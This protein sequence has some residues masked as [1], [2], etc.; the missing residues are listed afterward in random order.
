MIPPRRV[1]VTGASGFIGRHVVPQLVERGWDVHAVVYPAGRVP[2][3]ATATEHEVN[4]LAP[5]APAALV[6]RVRPAYLM[7]LAW[8][9]VPGRF[10]SD[11]D[12]LDW[13]AASLALHR[14]FA[15]AGGTR[16]VYAGT[17]AE[18]DWSHSHLDET[19][20]PLRPATLYGTAKHALRQLLEAV[21]PTLG[22]AVAWGRVFFLYGPYEH[23]AR[24]VPDVM[25]ALL[26]GREAHCTEGTQRRDLMH[27][28]D[29]AGAF[30]AVLE[31]DHTG[32]V[33][34]ASGRCDPLRDTI[35]RIGELAGCSDLVRLGARPMPAGEPPCLEAATDVLSKR[36]GF[37]PRYT[38][39]SG[40]SATLDWWRAQPRDGGRA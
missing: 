18:Y 29:V 9:A 36:I 30:V 35:L 38:L 16:A 10:W 27:V 17:C 22:V 4:L 3:P 5:G 8:N 19:G 21:T 33:N 26:D 40:L 25:R 20:T 12:N 32:A 2:L 15:A 1:L 14:A 7:H 11:P 34:I 37:V 39:E 31:S 24:L 23:R 28:E 6:E 13:V